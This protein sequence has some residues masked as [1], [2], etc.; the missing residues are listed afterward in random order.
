MKLTGLIEN[1]LSSRS[2]GL[3]PHTYEYSRNQCPNSSR[4]IAEGP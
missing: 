1:E 4:R 3:G 2:D